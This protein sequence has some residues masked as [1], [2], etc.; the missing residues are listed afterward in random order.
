MIKN[1]N[2]DPDARYRLSNWARFDIDTDETDDPI[3]CLVLHRNCSVRVKEIH[4]AIVDSLGTTNSNR[5]MVGTP[6][7]TDVFFV[8]HFTST[9]ASVSVDTVDSLAPTTNVP[10]GTPVIA[11][12]GTTAFVGAGIVEI[13]VGYEIQDR[14]TA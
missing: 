9:N 4:Y 7:D 13:A 10:A 6:G 1:R 3:K 2:L 12:I 11:S 5:I 14:A 8:S